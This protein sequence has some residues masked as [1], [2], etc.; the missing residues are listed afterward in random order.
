M[1]VTTEIRSTEE[2]LLLMCKTAEEML[3]MSY[4][5]L[6]HEQ[7]D[8]G[9]MA[10]KLGTVIQEEMREILEV[11][12][13]RAAHF[14]DK[15]ATFK[16]YVAVVAHLERISDY[17]MIILQ[18]IRDK[19]EAQARFSTAAMREL[20]FLFESLQY[21][22]RCARDALQTSNPILSRYIADTTNTLDASA[23][24]AARDHEDRVLS[25]ECD[26]KASPIFLDLL[27]SL[28]GIVR[29]MRLLAER[30]QQ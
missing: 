27:D 20:K 15:H 28:K 13:G 5:T 4:E 19:M 17:T 7:I 12:V 21:L 10:E 18:A 29:H 30:L 24:Q 26:A 2:R 6:K 14:P 1:T 22:L 11:V 9:D 8:L 25:G 3:Q 23:D 16:R